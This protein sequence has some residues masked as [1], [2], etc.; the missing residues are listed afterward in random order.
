M[1]GV[2]NYNTPAS[3]NT[4]VVGQSGAYVFVGKV[5]YNYTPAISYLTIATTP[6]VNTIYM[7][8]RLN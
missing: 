5:S 7:S 4:P 8:P 6:M 2:G 1:Q 3:G